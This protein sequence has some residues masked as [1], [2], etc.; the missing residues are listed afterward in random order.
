MLLEHLGARSQRRGLVE[1]GAALSAAVDALLGDPATRTKDLGGAL[2]TN[3][4]GA[5]VAKALAAN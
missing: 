1:A 2:G 3:A 5:A 4:F